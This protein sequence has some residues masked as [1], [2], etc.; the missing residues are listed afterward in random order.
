MKPLKFPYSNVTFTKNQPGYLPLPAWSDGM[1]VVTCWSLSWSERLRMLR[2][3]RIW[4]RQE[5]HGA[6]LQAMR[7]QVLD[8]FPSMK[9]VKNDNATNE[10][11]PKQ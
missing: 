5:N 10:Q 9:L 11:E 1:K 4:V 6:P 2:T 8:P 7:P 3:G